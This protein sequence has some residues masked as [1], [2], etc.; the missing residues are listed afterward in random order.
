MIVKFKGKS[1]SH[2]IQ[3][4]NFGVLN[5]LKSPTL[6][7]NILRKAFHR[8]RMKKYQAFFFLIFKVKLKDLLMLLESLFSKK[9]YLFSSALCPWS[10]MLAHGP[11]VHRILSLQFPEID[12]YDRDE[13]LSFPKKM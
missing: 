8:V 6:F 12:S 3:H 11:S 7:E 2:L 5:T 1:E 9:G 4:R 13:V 10:H